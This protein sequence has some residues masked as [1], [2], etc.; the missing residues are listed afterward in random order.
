MKRANSHKLLQVLHGVRQR[1][2]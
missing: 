1:C 2:L